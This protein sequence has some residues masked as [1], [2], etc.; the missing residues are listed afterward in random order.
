VQSLL[1]AEG[2]YRVLGAAGGLAGLELVREQQPALV[3][4]DLEV[5]VVDGF[6]VGRRLRSGEAE[7]RY[8]IESTRR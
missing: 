4:L 5:P 6:E 2:R 8:Q 7:E 3:L 1:E